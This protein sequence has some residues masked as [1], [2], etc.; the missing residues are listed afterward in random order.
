M[1]VFMAGL[2]EKDQIGKR[3]WLA[4]TISVADAKEKPLLAMVPKGRKIVNTLARWQADKYDD[5]VTDG[6]VDGKDVESYE[7][8]AEYRQ[9][10][11]V[12]CQKVRRTAKVSEM[13]EDVS[14][15]AGAS[16]GELARSIDKKL[17]EIGR[18]IEATLC[19]DNDTQAD[20]GTNAYKT[21]GLGSW[22]NNSAQSVLPV[23]SAFRTP[24]A[25]INATAMASL[26]E[27]LFKGVL[28]S[29]YEQRGKNQ[30][31]ILLCG[32]ALKET[33]S[34]FTQV[35][36]GATNVYTTIRAY[37]QD[38]NNRKIINNILVYEGDFNTVKLVPSL[39]LASGTSNAPTRR[40]YV[41]DMDMLELSWNKMPQVKQLP[42][43]DGGP[44]AVV[45]A[46]FCLKVLNPLGLGKFAATS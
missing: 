25:S 14:N 16:A 5:P 28:K 41:L 32:T 27:A 18:D 29:V 6:V 3:E 31:L 34:S 21:R 26:T 12:Y 44:R 38:I 20:D 2:V 13:A 42:D 45:K 4:D 36:S 33:I 11:S 46:I 35:S 30:D 24:A 22:I 8:A 37:N 40:G 19:S 10:L 39:L 15:V 17:E 9:E 43:L 7:N 23:P 1:E